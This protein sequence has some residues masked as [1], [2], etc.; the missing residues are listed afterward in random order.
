MELEFAALEDAPVGARVLLEAL[1]EPL[2]VPVER[3][4]VLHD[5]L[6]H[7]EEAAARARLVPI[8]RLEVIEDL[9]QVAVRADLARVERHRLLVRHWE[10]ERAAGAVLE[11]VELRDVVAPALAPKLGRRQDGH[12]HLLPTDRVHLLADDLRGLLVDRPPEREVRPE[13]RAHLAD[14]PAANE[15]A[16]AGGLGVPRILPQR[17]DEELRRPGH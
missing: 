13:P 17:R 4:G 16:M 10:D 9:G 11:L 8:L 15:Q 1:V 6:A 3:V 14:E 7:A 5:E 12:Q 2:V